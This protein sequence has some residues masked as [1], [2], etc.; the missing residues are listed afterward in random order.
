MRRHVIKEESMAEK[1]LD[2]KKYIEIAHTRIADILSSILGLKMNEK[3]K[4]TLKS[5]KSFN[6]TSSVVNSVEYNEMKSVE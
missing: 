4:T 2:D 5:K 1:K 6:S 3:K